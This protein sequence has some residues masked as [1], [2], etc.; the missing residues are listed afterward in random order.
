M[1]TFKK[2]DQE[3]LIYGFNWA[4]WLSTGDTL[5]SSTWVVPA[6]LTNEGEQVS[7]DTT[8]IKIG[9]GTIGETYE[10]VNE[11]TTTTTDET[12][13]RTFKVRVISDK[14]K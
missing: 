4:D 1:A 10:V 2:A 9:G 6:G 3:I 14:Y 8:T 12:S 11:I 13:E 5:Q 7:S